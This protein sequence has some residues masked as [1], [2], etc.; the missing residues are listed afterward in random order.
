MCRFASIRR[1]GAPDRV[2]AGQD[3]G[4]GRR[5]WGHAPGLTIL[6]ANIR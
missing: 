2:S 6:T 5:G 4:A 3:D 1:L